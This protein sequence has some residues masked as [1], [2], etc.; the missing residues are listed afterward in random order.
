[1]AGTWTRIKALF[2]VDIERPTLAKSMHYNW[3]VLKKQP[4][5]EIAGCLGDLGFVIYVI[6]G[7][8]FTNFSELIGHFSR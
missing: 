7:S 6:S 2:N 4:I 5:Q 3:Q 1:M 8:E